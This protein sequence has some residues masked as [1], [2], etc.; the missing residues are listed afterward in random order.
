MGKML[1]W[2]DVREV[3]VGGTGFINPST[4]ASTF[5]DATRVADIVEA[6]PDVIV[7]SATPNDNSYTASAITAAALAA[8]QAYRTA[9][10]KAL[11]IVGGIFPG[12]TGPGSTALANENAV[13]AAF[14]QWADGNSW[15]IPVA[16]DPTGSWIFGTGKVGAANNSG[17][18]DLY[19]N[20]ADTVHPSQDGHDYFAR[21]WAAAIRRKVLA[22]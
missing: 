4:Y 15:F 11:I 16:T 19:V 18:S 17:N 14:D 6:N 5:G 21:R 2:T 10:P 8:F 7:V 1:G 22:A 20:S 9:M 12:S 3:A 13:K